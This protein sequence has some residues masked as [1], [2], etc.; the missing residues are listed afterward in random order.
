MINKIISLAI[1]AFIGAVS[2]TELSA[3]VEVK[4][5]K[6][7]IVEKDVD[8][9]GKVIEKKVVLEGEDAEKYLRE[10]Q[11]LDKM[12]EKEIESSVEGEH[13]KVMKKQAFKIKVKNENGEEEILE[14][15]GEGEM[16]AKMKDLIEKEGISIGADEM[17]GMKSMDKKV[18][19]KAIDTD[20]D[21]TY[22]WDGEGEM[23]AELKKLLD[24]EGI[25]LGNL[26]NETDEM[27]QTITMDDSGSGKKMKIIK[28]GAGL[29][30]VMDLDWEG[31]V[32]PDEV[33]EVL[34]QEGIA[35]EEIVGEN[36]EKQIKIIKSAKAVKEAEPSGGKPQLG[37]MIEAGTNGV[38]VSE[39]VPNSSAAEGGIIA[40]DIITS[41]DDTVVKSTK[42][43]IDAVQ[44]YVPGDVVTVGLNRQGEAITKK[45]TLK[46]YVDPYPFKTWE[47]VMENGKNKS[48][49][50]EKEIIIKKDK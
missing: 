41:L 20:T 26:M 24:K 15:D 3:Q 17:Q 28:K 44:T 50:I 13:Q 31:D 25:D 42:D 22:E 43:L 46:A 11:D 27:T 37:V 5:T 1:F 19:I 30:E 10:N 29:E 21:N 36:G 45:M 33:R 16:P 35:L 47:E 40:G 7:V 48:I 49:E 12:I 4:K 23:P 6:I 9:N 39:V 2:M 14:W 34:E 8:D 38:K 32:L 18:R